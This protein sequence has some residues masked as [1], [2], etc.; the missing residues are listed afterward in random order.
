MGLA[1]KILDVTHGVALYQALDLIVLV[2]LGSVVT[3]ANTFHSNACKAVQAMMKKASDV[4]Q[5]VQCIKIFIIVFYVSR[6]ACRA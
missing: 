4:G 3:I 1:M 5:S 2:R 6:A